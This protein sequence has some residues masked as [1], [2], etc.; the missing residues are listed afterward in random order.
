MLSNQRRAGILE[1]QKVNRDMAMIGYFLPMAPLLSTWG[2]GV[3]G[4]EDRASQV[5]NLPSLLS[6]Q[7]GLEAGQQDC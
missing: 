7:G 5:A 1:P 4:A 3:E 6:L 2:Q